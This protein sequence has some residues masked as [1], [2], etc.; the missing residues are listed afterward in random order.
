MSP[1]PFEGWA[2]AYRA[3]ADWPLREHL[4]TTKVRPC[5]GSGNVPLVCCTARLLYTCSPPQGEKGPHPHPHPSPKI[6]HPLKKF[7]TSLPLSL[8]PPLL[9]T[10]QFP[11]F[12]APSAAVVKMWG[13]WRPMGARGERM[14]GPGST[15]KKGGTRRCLPR[16]GGTRGVRTRGLGSDGLLGLLLVLPAAIV[17]DELH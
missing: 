9:R 13:P 5:A 2:L 12:G 11:D 3:P 7:N 15:E 16:M 14:G 17:L 10:G 6:L 8:R 1:L 4:G